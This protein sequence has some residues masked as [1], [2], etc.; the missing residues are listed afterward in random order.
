MNRWALP[1]LT[2]G[3]FAPDFCLPTLGNPAFHFNT[4][5]GR[6]VL[7]SLLPAE[8]AHRAE[9]LADFETV[10]GLFDDR[11]LT[12]FHITT[13]PDDVHGV[14]DRIPGQRWFFDI[15]GAVTR[16]LSDAGNSPPV[17]LLFDPTLRLLDC[18]PR[19][20]FP[21]LAQRLAQLP[22]PGLHAGCSQDA[23]V[24][25]APRVFE[26]EFCRRLIAEYDT[27]GGQ[28]T[29]VMRDIGG[30]TVGVIDEMKRRRDVHIETA[31]LK[32][33]VVDRLNRRLLPMVRRAFQFRATRIE[34]YLVACYSAE[35]GGYV[36]PHRDNQTLGTAHRRFA[37]SINLNAETFEGGDLRFPEFGPQTY[38]PPTG[39]AVVFCCSLL[40]EATAVTRG[41]R[42]AF[43]PFIH[44]EGAEEVR[45]RNLR[46]LADAPPSAP[47]G[48]L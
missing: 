24:L 37:V 16:R 6:Y 46:F 13:T 2:L 8:P 17:W 18:A 44:D 36:R 41:R 11:R 39:A 22:P 15:D 35:E 5:G 21:R 7:L 26:P 48:D 27:Q 3:E 43:L 31:D 10:R 12:A 28:P 20:E 32:Q 14:T 23:P 42:Y 1:A 25:I 34:R 45:Q 9:V 47:H 4:L 29:G 38:R 33:M 30:R 40:H 19:T